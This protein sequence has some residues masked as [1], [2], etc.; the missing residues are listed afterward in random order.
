[1]AKHAQL[2][3]DNQLCFPLYAASRAM[4][5]AYLPLLEPFDL[6]YPQYLTMLAVWSGPEAQTVGELGARL[7]L[8]S[9]TLTPL[10]KRL[11]ARG[12]VERHRDPDDERRVLVSATAEG[13]SLQD[14]LADVPLSLA[15]RT[16]LTLEDGI[17]FRRL[18]DALLTSLDRHEE[19]P[20]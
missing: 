18:L 16:G 19:T 8:D 4:T 2:E 7:R 15:V 20:A 1:M 3:L 11:E 17:E 14:E 9:G 6:T 5:R 13:T 12:L 10:L